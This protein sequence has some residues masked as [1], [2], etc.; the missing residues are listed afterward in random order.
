MKRNNKKKKYKKYNNKKHTHTH[1][2]VLGVIVEPIYHNNIPHQYNTLIMALFA[3]DLSKNNTS[4]WVL[5]LLRNIYRCMSPTILN[6]WFSFSKQSL[7]HYVY[8]YN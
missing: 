8:Y 1:T 7:L 5:S 3:N 2:L 4:Y 6:K